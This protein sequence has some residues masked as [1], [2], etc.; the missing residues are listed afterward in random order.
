MDK[1]YSKEE[2]YQKI[3]EILTEEF[4]IEQ[5]KIKDD[6]NLFTDLDLDSIDAVD[7]AVRLQQFTDKRISPEEFKQIKTV[8]D[9]VEAVYK[10]V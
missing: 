8:K 4:E 9:V 10:L 3:C 1:K 2:I 7:M 5:T 6:A